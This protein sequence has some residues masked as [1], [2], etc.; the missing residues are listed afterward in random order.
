MWSGHSACVGS[1]NIP[2]EETLRRLTFC[3]NLL[4]SSSLYKME[5]LMPTNPTAQKKY[6]PR[7]EYEEQPTPSWK[8]QITKQEAWAMMAKELCMDLDEDEEEQKE[9]KMGE[10]KKEIKIR[11][12]IGTRKK[13]QEE[14]QEEH[15]N[16]RPKKE[17]QAV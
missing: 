7:H 17:D 14:H 6:L 12:K 5:R 2:P 11:I 10:K 15:Q 8:M 1:V 4:P 9:D 16:K 13:G 3:V